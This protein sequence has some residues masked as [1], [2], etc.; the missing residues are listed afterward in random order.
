MIDNL[1]EKEI[2]RYIS[3]YESKIED[4]ESLL[5]NLKSLKLRGVEIGHDAL[6]CHTRSQL[7]AQKNAYIQAS[8]DFDSLLD[9]L[10]TFKQEKNYE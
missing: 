3:N 7:Y 8:A 5:T 6:N 9:Y 4:V 2:K 1:L 10:E